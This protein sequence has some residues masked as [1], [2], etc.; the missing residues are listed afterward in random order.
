MSPSVIAYGN[1]GERKC[2]LH[3]GIAT[4]F[5]TLIDPNGHK[6]LI[7]SACIDN[8]WAGNQAMITEER[9]EERAR[10]LI[11]QKLLGGI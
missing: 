3:G 1:L 11:Q 7:C 4:I 6:W 5:G 9:I 2:Q 10:E 8:F